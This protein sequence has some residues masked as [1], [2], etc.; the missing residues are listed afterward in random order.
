MQATPR[1][2]TEAGRREQIVT[3]AIDVIAE[4]GYSKASFAR[5]AERAGLSSTSLISYH[6]A[7]KQELV[8]QLVVTVHRRIRE[9]VAV[10]V[11]GRPTPTAALRAY[12]E[13]AV[14]FAGTHRTQMAALLDIFTSGALDH[15]AS[16]ERAAV[17]P[18]EQVLQW[19]QDTGE[20]RA[21]DVRVVATSIQR[22]VEGPAFLLAGEPALDLESYTRELVTLFELATRAQ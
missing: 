15:D 6:F 17:S 4:L 11:D 5:I 12:I 9:F 14:E 1:T 7:N 20:F 21:F 19:G 8:E 3:A 13:S 22:S 2:F 10:R 18:L 16:T